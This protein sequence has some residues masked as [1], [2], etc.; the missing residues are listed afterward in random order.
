VL[1][2]IFALLGGAVYGGFRVYQHYQLAFIT[3]GCQAG[4]GGNAIALDFGQAADAAT[5]A[6]VAVYD[7]L[8]V[9]ALTIAYATA[10]QESK[11]FSAA[12]TVVSWP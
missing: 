1:I 5:I 6:D 12:P 7:H 9:E 8:P 3:P 11:F 10:I 2:V 4:T